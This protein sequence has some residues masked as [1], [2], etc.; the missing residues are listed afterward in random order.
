[1]TTLADIFYELENE[2]STNGKIA[3]IQRN[4]DFPG[5]RLAL[6]VALDPMINFYIRK[7]PR[8]DAN[9]FGQ[10]GIT[11][12]V[13]INLLIDNISTRKIT[14]KK[15]AEYI[16]KIL[17]SVEPNID[18]N[19]VGRVVLKDLRCG[20]AASLVNKALGAGTVFTYPCM[21]CETMDEKTEKRVEFP[22][23]LQPKMDGMRFNAIVENG[24]VALYSRNGKPIQL[25]P[26]AIILQELSQLPDGMVYDGELLVKVDGVV[27]NRQTGNGI[28][29]KAIKETISFTESNQVHCTLWDVISVE[30][31]QGKYTSNHYAA[32]YWDLFYTVNETPPPADQQPTDVIYEFEGCT[33]DFPSTSRYSR[34]E[35]IPSWC[36]RSMDEV[37]A[38]HAKL[39]AAGHEGSVFKELMGRWENKRS[40]T[41][42]KVKDFLEADL[43]ITGVEEGTGKYAGMM[44]ALV[45]RDASGE[46]VTNVGTGFS[47]DLRKRIWEDR[48]RVYGLILPVKYKEKIHTKDTNEKS[49]FLP[50]AVD[51]PRYDKSEPDDLSV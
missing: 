11:P 3:I 28:L 26:D 46:Y 35:A 41:A 43:L 40:R 20:V 45:C 50:V 34:I 37:Y 14:G 30:A 17:A 12:T 19:I 31:F 32:R 25:H 13:A 6:K 24:S 21:L 49:L 5:F 47:D 29:N 8:P 38:I 48:D 51:E 1:M 22:A 23:Y 27:V 42:L 33:S 4:V 44:G 2:S 15:A 36:V 39:V 16:S 7:L 10:G 18:A 9:I